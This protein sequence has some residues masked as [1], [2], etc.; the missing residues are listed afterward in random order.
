VDNLRL[1][2]QQ[3]LRAAWR[4]RWLGVIVAWLVCGLGW[5]GVYMIPNQFESS[6]RLYV[7]A[8]AIL[9]PL[10]RGIAAESSPTTQLEVLQRTL[11]SRPNLEKLISKTDLDLTINTPADRERLITHLGTTIRVVPQTRNLFTITYRDT[12]PKLAHDVVQTLL[13]IFVESATGSNRSDMDNARR[14]LE[15][16][17][18]SYQQQL[19][20]AEKRR[21]DFRARY[22][23]ILPNA[24][25]PGVPALEAARNNVTNLEDALQDKTMARDA[26]QKEVDNTSPMLVAEMTP[27][28]MAQAQAARVETPLQ[29]AEERLKMLLL[30]DTENHPDVIAQKKLIAFLKTQ[31]APTDPTAATPA[32][33]ADA[34]PAMLKRSVPNPVYDQLK[35]KLI[36]A[37]SQIDAL[38]RQHDQAVA[39]RDKLEKIQ[40]EQPGLIAEYENTDRDYT[41]LRAAYEELLTRLQSANIAQAADTQADKVKLQ[42]VDPPEVPRLPAAPNRMLMVTGVLL[43]GLGAGLGV[44][45][46]FGQLDNSFS[47]ADDLRALGLPVLGGISVLGLASLRQRLTIAARFGVAVVLL[48]GIYGGLLVHILR[49]SALI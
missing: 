35:V 47:T 43:G 5:V 12:N 2:V 45:V 25:Q 29:Q 46:L 8:D 49:S 21:A 41:A 28:A 23:D 14:F 24:G 4:R 1:L 6:A 19:R 44:T 15:N 31:Q 10:L 20:A 18:A 22:V 11:L 17:I 13:T 37:D 9:T 34:R 39:Y 38:H 3:Y 26:L 42:I 48:V 16:Q 32:K 30:T 7:D 27:G 33:A 36:D 40:R